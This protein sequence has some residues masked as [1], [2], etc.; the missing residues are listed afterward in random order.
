[1]LNQALWLPAKTLTYKLLINFMPESDSGKGTGINEQNKSAT[2]P[3][4]FYLLV[5]GHKLLLRELLYFRL[6]YFYRIFLAQIFQP[7]F[8]QERL[9]IGSGQAAHLVQVFITRR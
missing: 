1:M 5:L 8:L 4:R 7:F 9:V 2:Q 3:V 6:V